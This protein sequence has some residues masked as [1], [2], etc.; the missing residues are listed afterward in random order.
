MAE[1]LL[2]RDLLVLSVIGRFRMLT[3]PQVKLWFFAD[4]SEP[5]VTRFVKRA[6]AAGYLG[7]E[8]IGGNGMQVLWLTRRGRD[9]LVAR[10]T[11]AADL[12]PAT[13]PSAAK[14]FAHTVAIGDVAAWLARREPAPDELLPAWALQRYFGGKLRVIPDLLALW[15]PIGSAPGAALAVEVDLGTEPL[16]SVFLPKLRGLGAALAAWLPEAVTRILVLVP[17]KRRA[18]S[19]RTSGIDSPVAVSV[20][21]MDETIAPLRPGVKSS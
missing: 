13:G 6:E 21:V 12:F 1:K 18:D 5:V 3:R 9:V 10:G 8:R 11:P 14:D 19:L 16:E 4:L 2:P 15:R 17:S 7:V 20:E